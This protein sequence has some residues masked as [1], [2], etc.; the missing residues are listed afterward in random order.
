MEDNSDSEL[1]SPS[2]LNQ[3]TSRDPQKID[4]LSS[5]EDELHFVEG[6][7]EVDKLVF[8]ERLQEM[9]KVVVSVQAEN[10]RLQT[11][12]ASQSSQDSQDS[13]KSVNDEVQDVQDVR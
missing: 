9:E 1:S 12:F 3:P 7:M 4:N 10:R 8:E 11:M 5:L 13:Y 6:R 2:E